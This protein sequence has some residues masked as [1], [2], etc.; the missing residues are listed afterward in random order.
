MACAYL[1][2]LPALLCRPAAAAT[3]ESVEEYAL[4]AAF[5]YK[6]TSFVTWP[7]SAAASPSFVFCVLG[8]GV[9]IEAFRALEGREVKGRVVRVLPV[10][11]SSVGDSGCALLFAAGSK[12]E[13]WPSLLAHLAGRGILTVGEDES[14]VAAG[15]MIALL[16]VGNKLRF[17]VNLRVAQAEGFEVSSQLLGLAQAVY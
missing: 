16:P 7:K 13:A 17:E 10:T 9:P 11:A 5:A 2:L 3:D 8:D 4:K 14:F 15:G 6:F 1:S 12:S